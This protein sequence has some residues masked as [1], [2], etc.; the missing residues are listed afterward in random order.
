MQNYAYAHGG[1]QRGPRRTGPEYEGFLPPLPQHVD[2][3]NPTPHSANTP[4]SSHSQLPDRTRPTFGIDLAE[5]MARDSVEVP[6]IM[7]KCCEAIE[8]YGISTVGVYRIGGTM[9][10]VTRLKEK[11]DKDLDATNLDAEEWSGDISN[12][13]SVLKL[14]LREL[15]EPLLTTHLHQGFLS[16]AKIE[17]DRLRHIRLHERV[18]ELP[19]ANYATLKYFL[20]HLYRIVQ[21]EAQNSMSIGNL[22]I[23]FG[24]TLFPTTA[25]NGVNGQDG[26][27]GA[28]IQ[29]KAIET[30]L[31]HYT[32]I[33][34][35]ESEAS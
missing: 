16:A 10:K 3:T 22:A 29:N 7:V 33:F 24:P 17:N 28:T 21:N 25:P 34:V 5:Q 32:D 2:R 6:P 31:E 15:P 4:S 18:N 8:K 13:T 26:L 12:V 14:W 30:I 23:I 20:G 11:L 35:D 1:V 9:S 27:A 19:D